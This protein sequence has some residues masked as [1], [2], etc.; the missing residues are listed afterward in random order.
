[1]SYDRELLKCDWWTRFD[2]FSTDQQ[3]N[4]TRPDVRWH[5]P[6]ASTELIFPDRC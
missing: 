4:K 2:E 6:M 5:E 1:M 3:L